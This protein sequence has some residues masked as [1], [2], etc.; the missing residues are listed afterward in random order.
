[1]DK[2][3]ENVKNLSEGGAPKIRRSRGQKKFGI[4][5]EKQIPF[6]E[7]SSKYLDFSKANKAN[8]SYG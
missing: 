4:L 5:D 1:M 6:G 3:R 2:N 7:F 8:E